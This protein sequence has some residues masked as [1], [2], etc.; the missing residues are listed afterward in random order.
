MDLSQSFDARSP[1]PPQSKLATL[2]KENLKS[3]K[4]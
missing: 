3:L 2:N 1:D 4:D